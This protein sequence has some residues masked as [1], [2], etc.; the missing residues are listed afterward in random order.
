DDVRCEMFDGNTRASCLSFPSHIIP[1][2]S[3]IASVLCGPL[4]P[5]REATKWMNRMDDVRCEMFDGNTRASCLL[6]FPITHHTSNISHP[7][8]HVR[9]CPVP[10]ITNLCEQ[11]SRRPIGPRACRRSVLMPI[12][13]P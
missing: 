11:S 5:L 7:P 6:R 8:A 1:Q 4:R 12:S 2:S 10:S 13:A 3:Y 9:I